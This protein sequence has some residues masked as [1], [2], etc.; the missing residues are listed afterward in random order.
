MFESVY[1]LLSLL[2]DF[3]FSAFTKDTLY[4]VARPI[5]YGLENTQEGNQECGGWKECTILE[6]KEDGWRV[7]PSVTYAHSVL[8]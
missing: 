5:S 6:W 7:V 8:V 2:A 4:V 1:Q 3:L